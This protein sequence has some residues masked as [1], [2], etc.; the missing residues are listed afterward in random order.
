[1][2]DYNIKALDDEL[3]T[4]STM[5]GYRSMMVDIVLL[6]HTACAVSN[7]PKDTLDSSTYTKQHQL[8]KLA[9]IAYNHCSIPFSIPSFHSIF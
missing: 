5:L 6:A 3:A 9:A 2:Q 1:M 4:C 8:H 7:S